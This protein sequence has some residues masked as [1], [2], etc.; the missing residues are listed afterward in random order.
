MPE[1]MGE[2]GD[3]ESGRLSRP[4]LGLDGHVLAFQRSVQGQ[5]LDGS[6]VGIAPIRDGQLQ[7]GIEVE[8]R[9]THVL[10]FLDWG[11]TL[12]GEYSRERSHGREVLSASF[13]SYG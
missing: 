5:L 2:E 4:R 12:E 11:S 6:Q 10:S 3:Q 1:G 13:L 9:K 7:L 8:F